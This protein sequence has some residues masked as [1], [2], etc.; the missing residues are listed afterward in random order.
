ML[1]NASVN[2]T[3][4][5]E[6]ETLVQA[7]RELTFNH[8]N[9]H[10]MCFPHVINVCSTHVIEGFT[11]IDLVDKEFDALLPP[12]DP[13][14]QSYDDAV[15]RD[16][17]AL[18]HCIIR[19]VRASGQR[20]DLFASIIRDGNEKGWF[21]SPTNSR[22]IVKVPQLQLL[23]DVKTHWDSI[24]FMIHRCREMRLVCNLR[25]L[26]TICTSAHSE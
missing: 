19:A 9:N 23:R 6:Y 8:E 1:N 7:T 24:Y 13:D 2:N 14:C 20:L 16:P 12:R 15:T 3:F 18:C 10:I 17:I 21:I 11:N 4:L 26:T 22:Q 25:L 5:E